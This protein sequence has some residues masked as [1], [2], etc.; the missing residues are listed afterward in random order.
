MIAFCRHD[1]R[2]EKTRDLPIKLIESAVFVL[3]FAS[4]LFDLAYPA[5]TENCFRDSQCK[6]FQLSKLKASKILED[7]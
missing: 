1:P 3:R 4:S 2:N 5:L 6:S 7:F